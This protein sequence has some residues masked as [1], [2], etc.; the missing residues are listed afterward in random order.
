MTSRRIGGVLLLLMAAGLFWNQLSTDSSRWI[1]AAAMVLP[2][3]VAGTAVFAGKQW[4]VFTG[5]GVATVGLVIGGF[6]A[7]QA[8]LGGGSEFTAVLDFL[9]RGWQLQQL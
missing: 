7:A 9:R 8:N 6:V 4:E 2:F 3:A 5:L 1:L